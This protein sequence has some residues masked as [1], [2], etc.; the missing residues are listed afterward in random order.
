LPALLKEIAMACFR[1]LPDF[2]SFRMF[3]EIVFLLFPDL[4]GMG[5]LFFAKVKKKASF[6]KL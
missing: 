4:R 1:G 3:E 2:I 5:V 6:K